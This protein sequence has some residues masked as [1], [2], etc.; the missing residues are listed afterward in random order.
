MSTSDLCRFGPR[1]AGRPG[2]TLIELLVVIAIIAILAAMLLPALSKAKAK[3]QSIQCLSNMK[4]WGLATVMYGGDN[5]D[6][7]PLFGDVYP[8][9]STTLFWYQKLAPYVVKASAAA[10]GNMEA[11]TAEVRKCPAGK[12][13]PPPLASSVV[14]GWTEWNCWIGVYYGSFGNPLTGPFYYGNNMKPI[15]ATRIKKP[16]DAMLYMDAVTHY[17][18]S[19]MAWAFD[20]DLDGDGMMDSSAGVYAGEFS[21]NNA[22][23]TVHNN[24]ANVALLDG[25]AERVPFKKLWEWRNRQIVHSFWYLED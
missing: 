23:P 6:K 12:V 17:V 13:G 8:Y 16:A 2:F 5:D 20:K 22:R 21:F 1:R 7:L 3:A 9:T 14:A 19:P 4:Q 10:P 15:P 24:G 18:Y 11:Y 25:H